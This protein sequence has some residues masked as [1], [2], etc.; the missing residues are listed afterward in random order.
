MQQYVAVQDRASRVIVESN[1]NLYCAIGREAY[2][3][4]P[5]PV[6]GTT[7][8]PDY[9]KV[10]DVNMK[11]M[12]RAGFVDDLPLFGSSEFYRMIRPAGVI[13]LA[14]DEKRAFDQIPGGGGTA[15]LRVRKARAGITSGLVRTHLEF[16]DSAL[17]DFVVR[18]RAH[19][20]WR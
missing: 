18:Y 2:S 3:I 4:A 14:I 13:G 11:R 19:Q 6:L 12:V 8:G 10:I 9:L 7:I 20:R 1:S 15:G 5:K 17:S 16:Q